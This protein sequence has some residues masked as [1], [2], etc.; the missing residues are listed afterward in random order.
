MRRLLRVALVAAALLVAAPASATDGPV[1]V[2]LDRSQRETAVG[3]RFTFTS[4]IRNDTG[5]ELTGLVAHLGVFSTLPQVY[6]DP[7]D[8][9]PHRTAFLPPIPAHE[10]RQVEWQVQ[11]VNEGE[12]VL[13]VAVTTTSGPTD[14][15]GSPSLRLTSTRQQSLDAGG[16]LPVVLGVPALFGALLVLVALRRRRL[17]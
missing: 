4:T 6:V 9:S 3:D 12:F 7:E 14:V 5:H 15:V 2:T 10:T 11:V 16:V 17:N 13:Y 1:S 8:W